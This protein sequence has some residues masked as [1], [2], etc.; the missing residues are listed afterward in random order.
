MLKDKHKEKIL[1]VT[2]ESHQS[3]TRGKPRR[4]KASFLSETVEA[5][6]QVG[7][8]QTDKRKSSQPRILYPAKLSSKSEAELKI[9]TDK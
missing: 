3:H 7:H 6:R 5:R 2:R 1:K 4:L 9:F 8:I